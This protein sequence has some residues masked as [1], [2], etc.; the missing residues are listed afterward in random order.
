MQGHPSG[1]LTRIH[2][3]EAAKIIAPRFASEAVGSPVELAAQF[4]RDQASQNAILFSEQPYLGF[5]RG[6]FQE[7]LAASALAGLPEDEQMATLF[8]RPERL[9]APEW[10]ETIRFLSGFLAEGAEA[11]LD[12]AFASLVGRLLADPCAPSVLLASALFYSIEEEVVGS[13]YRVRAPGVDALANCAQGALDQSPFDSVEENV[14]IRAAEFCARRV[15]KASRWAEQPGGWFWMGAQAD[16]AGKRGFDS[17]AFPNEG[18][19]HRVWVAPFRLAATPVTVS[20]WVRFMDEGGYRI[21]E[22]WA[23][24]SFGIW[25]GPAGWPPQISHP[26]SR[27]WGQLVRSHGLVRL[28]R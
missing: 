18:P 1:R 6:L 15:S 13:S 11:R 17:D 27:H 22:F 24:G 25:S 2:E 28:V 9:Y 3:G 14:R 4:L 23:A 12:R 8:G 21:Q 5:S 26:S 20:Q 16:Q 19:P 7:L 10:L